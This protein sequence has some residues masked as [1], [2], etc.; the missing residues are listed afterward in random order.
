M[1]GVSTIGVVDKAPRKVSKYKE[2]VST[3]EVRRG[4]V[5]GLYSGGVKWT[6]P[7]W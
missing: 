7:L 6:R 4:E 3:R 1:D 2:S 5:S